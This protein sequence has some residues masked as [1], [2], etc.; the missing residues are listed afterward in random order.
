MAKKTSYLIRLQSTESGYFVIRKKARNPKFGTENLRLKKYDPNVRR[1][2]WFE[3]KKMH[4]HSN[5]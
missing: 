1:H 2:V 5:K 4:S 3:E